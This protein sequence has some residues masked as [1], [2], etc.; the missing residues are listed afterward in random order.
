METL[1]PRFKNMVVNSKLIE[2]AER[3]IEVYGLNT[4]AGQ[5]ASKIIKANKEPL[6]EYV[7]RLVPVA[8]VPF[9]HNKE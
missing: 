4:L 5:F 9:K 2:E 6:G 8:L 3:V 1:S 7:E